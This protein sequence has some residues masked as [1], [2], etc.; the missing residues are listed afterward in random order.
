MQLQFE[1]LGPYTIGEKLGA[2]GMGTVYAAVN[3][4]TGQEA[5]VKVLAPA[6]AMQRGF[7][8]RF[9]SEIESLKKLRH[10]NIVNLFG[11]GQK[12][13]F[14]FYAME[15]VDGANLEE[16]LCQ[17]RRFDWREVTRIGI[18]LSRALKL[19][20]DHG[21]IHRD[22][23]PANV[24]VGENGE[25]KLSDFGVA[26]LFGNTGLT[27][28]GG[29]LGT[30]EYMAPEQADGGRVTHHC[31]LYSLGGVLYALLAGR[32]P[33]RSKS[34][35]ELLQLQRFATPDGVRRY[36]PEAP[37][38][39]EQIIAQLLAKKPE[40][41]FPNALMLT[42]RLEAMEKGLTLQDGA[43]AE[44]A[45]PG[46]TLT[47]LGAA[48]RN[49][50]DAG[51]ILDEPPEQDPAATMARELLEREASA[52]DAQTGVDTAGTGSSVLE[53][54][55]VARELRDHFTTIEEDRRRQ[56]LSEQE[57]TPLISWPTIFLIISLFGIAA[58]VWYWASPPSERSLL[59][60]IQ[61]AARTGDDGQLRA[62]EDQ[63]GLFL[64]LYPDSEAVPLVE[65]LEERLNYVRLAGRAMRQ[66]ETMF[67][68]FPDS[69]AA[70]PYVEAIKLISTSP[71][72]ALV[73]LE[74]LVDLF[75]DVPDD[76][77][78]IRIFVDAADRQIPRLRDRVSR[79]RAI[80]RQE[81]ERQLERASQLIASDRDKA[82]RMFA[83]V[84]ALWGTETWAADLVTQARE[85]LT[86]L[87]VEAAGEDSAPS[88]AEADAATAVSRQESA[89]AP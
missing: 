72:T 75:G 43:D 11:Y 71:E 13:A 55:G 82:R 77:T 21:V 9:E 18:K 10:P 56:L 19:A 20:H 74:A 57:A 76:Q 6:L 64:R 81:I 89:V 4:D 50:S 24:L 38:E 88:P 67:R 52:A 37:R 73:R 87:A 79:R 47:D 53:D 69:I 58:L 2:G 44:A 62:V 70:G 30:A 36:A 29:V 65:E 27:N 22:I 8:E 12:D 35:L 17:G 33:F 23:K 7:R 63:I 59:Q 49:G 25:V 41:R 34:M 14:L 45:S 85:A 83:S 54:E 26:R 80:Y 5:A 61:A 42:R 46:V 60:E 78:H 31:D 15:R 39:L 51:V 28:E 16:E 40:E 48:K 68:R 84:V 66:A 86:A 32:P 1:K 3:S